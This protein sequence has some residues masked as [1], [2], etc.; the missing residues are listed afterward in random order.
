[1]SF[2]KDV[3]RIP[4]KIAES[5]SMI[6]AGGKVL[7]IIRD[8]TLK[9]KFL[10][11]AKVGATI[12]TSKSQ[13]STKPAPIPY[14]L[15]RAKAKKKPPSS[16]PVFTNKSGTV[17]VILSRGYK[18]LREIAGKQSNHVVMS[19]SGRMMRNFGIRRKSKDEVVLD[20][21]D[22]YSER[23]ARYHNIEGAGKSKVTHPFIGLTQAEASQ[24]VDE[25]DK[26]LNKALQPM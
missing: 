15:Y 20:F 19:W 21:S 25:V 7:S 12:D 23:L 17:M 14:G 5:V 3:K 9:G 22:S 11:E 2:E 16:M 24:V 6:R 8:R 1:M 18:Q 4:G 26:M 13:Y 10:S